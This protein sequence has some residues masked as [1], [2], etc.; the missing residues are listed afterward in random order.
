M[1]WFSLIHNGVQF[2]QYVGILQVGRTVIEVLPK[3][4]TPVN[5][6]PGVQ[7]WRQLVVR[8]LLEAGMPA[9]AITGTAELQV[10]RHSIPEMYFSLFLQET[11]Y[12]LHTGL[13]KEY[14]QK[15]ANTH[16]LKGR[17]LFA[18]QVRQNAVHQ[19]R[20]YVRHTVYDTQHR[21]HAIIY[22]TLC[23]LQQ[24]NL[25]P[26]L[27]GRINTL[28]LHF[29]EMPDIQVTPAL[30]EKTVLT[31]KTQR[32]KK[33]LDIARFI[34]LR[35]HPDITRGHNP[36]LALM[37]D[38]EKLWECFIAVTLRKYG[39]GVKVHA[40]SERGFWQPENGRVRRVRADLVLEKENKVCVLDTKWKR[41]PDAQPAIED[42][43]QLYVYHHYYKA[44]TVA[45]VYPG[46]QAGHF[47]PGAYLEPGSA[48]KRSGYTC[49]L[50]A[51]GLP[52][53]VNGRT[54][55]SEWQ[56]QIA[57]L[58]CSFQENNG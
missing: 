47:R 13:A 32:Y 14:R 6:E 10:T 19:E 8:M 2:K 52:G 12:L 23:L 35:Y 33:A 11:E 30:F 31:R 37:F 58:L 7:H 17:L 46:G 42:L 43:R 18:R 40:Q 16:A 28:L 57:A 50:V 5:G 49:K 4:D 15:E 27:Q 36:V 39:K 29:P 21:L 1:P 54:Q 20:F 56:K 22:K 25:V 34:L 44:E 53:F 41:F 48:N 9:V 38:M 24:L 51:L 55:I 45:L 26:A 3:A